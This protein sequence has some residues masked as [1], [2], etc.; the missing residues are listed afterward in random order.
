MTEG[1]PLAEIATIAN[2]PGKQAAYSG[3]RKASPYCRIW[4]R[5]IDVAASSVGLVTLAPLLIITSVLIKCTSRGP[6]LFWQNRVGRGGRPFRIAKFRSMVADADKK[7]LDITS[8]GDHR[9]TLLG[10]TL[11]RFKIDELPQLWNVLIGEMSLVGPRPEMPRYVAEYTE[12]QRRVLAVRPGIT[13]L[14][15]IQYRH[16]EKVLA[17][18]ESP[19]EFY[20]NVILPHKLDLNLEY[21]DKM[22]LSFDAKLIFQ[23]L[24]SLFV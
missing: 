19:E 23:T 7:G 6:V 14:A 8:S 18:S 3:A 9:V 10:V 13:D 16:E 2:G 24:K 20:R 5:V 11:R 22:S 1:R 15:S 12:D 4:K 17:Q 21:I